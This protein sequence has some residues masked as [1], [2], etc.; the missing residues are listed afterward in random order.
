MSLEAAQTARLERICTQL[1]LSPDDHVVEIGTGWGGLALH[2]ARSHGCRVTTTT[3]SKNQYDFACLRV[4]EA[5]LEDRI[6]VLYQDYRDLD[7]QFDKLVSVEMLEAVGPQFYDEYFRKCASLLKPDGRMLLQAIVMPEQRYAAYLKSVDFIQRYI[8]P[9]GCLPS[10][11]AM[12]DAVQ[13]T[14]NLRLLSLNDFA[15]GYAQTLR[16]WRKRFLARLDDVRALGYP[17][18]FIRMWDYY[19]CYCEGAFDERAVGV[20]HAMWGR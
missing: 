4:A 6:T 2:V 8:F 7:G 12:H 16:E 9:G 19:L 3:I 5:G 20:V 18:R 14:S 11:S 1:D 13:R 17:E 15:G 10:V